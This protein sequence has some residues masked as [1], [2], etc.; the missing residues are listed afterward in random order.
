MRL[1]GSQTLV[2]PITS[3]QYPQKARRPRFSVLDNYQLR[4]LG[5]DDM[6]PWQEALKDYMIA[7]GH[8]K[9]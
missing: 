5:M 7:K 3:E 9:E 1:A 4:L 6:R 8:I 2:T